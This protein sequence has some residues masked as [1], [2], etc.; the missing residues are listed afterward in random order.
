MVPDFPGGVVLVSLIFLAG[1]CFISGF[2]FLWESKD[3]AWVPLSIGAI[4]CL[5]V[6]V[7]WFRAQKDTDLENATPT[8]VADSFGNQIT[9]DTRALTSLV[10][11]KNIGELFTDLM[12]R[13]PL[14]E[15]DGLI[16]DKG[17]PIPNTEREA[18]NKVDQ[19]N[20]KAKE[21]TNLATNAFGIPAE[22]ESGI[23]PLVEEPFSTNIIGTNTGKPG[24]ASPRTDKA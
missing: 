19:A 10:A 9:T 14:P 13:E 8:T 17:N 21:I 4:L 5:F 15:P 20:D 24:K 16:D 11:V 3:Y 2:A 1:V 18:K 12:H 6:I 22:S 7:A 23:Q